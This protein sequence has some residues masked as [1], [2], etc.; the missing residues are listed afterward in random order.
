MIWMDFF[1]QVFVH[2][3]AWSLAIG[4]TLVVIGWG[5]WT[6]VRTAMGDA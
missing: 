6:L 1:L 5:V 2:A 4:I 3:L